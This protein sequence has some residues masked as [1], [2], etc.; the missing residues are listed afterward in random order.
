[1]DDFSFSSRILVGE[2]YCLTL[3]FQQEYSLGEG[4]CL[5]S[6]SW[7]EYQNVLSF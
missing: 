7:Q 2:R 5:T 1:M 3:V 6:V 4:Y